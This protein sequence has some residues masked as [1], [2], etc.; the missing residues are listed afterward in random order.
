[1]L[2]KETIGVYNENHMKPKNTLCEQNSELLI[3]KM[4]GTYSYQEL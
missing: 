3:V 4:G 2:F 1:M